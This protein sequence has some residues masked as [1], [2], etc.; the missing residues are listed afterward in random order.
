MRIRK[1]KAD[2][3]NVFTQVIC[4]SGTTGRAMYTYS[5]H[6]PWS[7]KHNKCAVRTLHAGHLMVAGL[8]SSRNNTPK[9]RVRASVMH[10]NLIWYYFE[11]CNTRITNELHTC[12]ML[13][14]HCWQFTACA[15]STNPSKLSNRF[16]VTRWQTYTY[17][18]FYN[19][20]STWQ[21]MLYQAWF[22]IGYKL[23]FFS[24]QWRH[25][26]LIIKQCSN[27]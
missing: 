3:N 1:R 25:Q 20:H 16:L 11:T 21:S 26:Q 17:K 9:I 23:L 12:Y 4:E 13:F 22:Q 24:K 6:P 5:W 14:C 10:S 15:T 7:Y 8:L 2:V 27:W 19:L 18:C